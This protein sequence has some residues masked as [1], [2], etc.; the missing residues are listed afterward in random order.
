MNE[1]T[2]DMAS[3]EAALKIINYH[4]YYGDLLPHIQMAELIYKANKS[5]IAAAIKEYQ[6][7]NLVSAL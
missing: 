4:A 5:S 3:M 7:G 6:E 2:F 1:K